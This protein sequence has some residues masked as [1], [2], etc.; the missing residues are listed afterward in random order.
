[1]LKRILLLLFT[2]GLLCPHLA[3][4]SFSG[5]ER[6]IIHLEGLSDYYFDADPQLDIAQVSGEA[7]ASRFTPVAE[8]KIWTG[9]AAPAAWLRFVVPKPELGE[10]YG[11][12]AEGEKPVSQWLL[13]VRPSFS[14]ILDHVD[15][16][17]PRRDGGFDQIRSGAKEV[18]R[19]SEP[20]SRFF[21]FELPPGAFDGKPCYLRL[22]SMTDVEVNLTIETSV[23]FAQNEG[24]D[25]IAY[26][27]LYGTLL[28]MV[29]YSLFPL[30]SLKDST[31]LYYILYIVSA[32]LWLF[33]VQGH[34]KLVFGQRPRFDQ[35]MLWLCVG[36]MITWGAIFT[37]SFLRLK[38]GRPVLFHLFLVIAVLGLA[39]S[40]AGLVGW[41]GLAFSMSHYLGLVLPI[42]AIAAAIA[43]L[44][45]GFSSAFYYLIAW[46][47]LA[48]GGFAFSLMGLK[49]LSVNFWTTNGM[50]IG[51]AGQSIFLSMA[52]TDRFKRLEIERNRLEKIQAHYR[53]LSLTDAPTGLYN[54]R[55]LT[56]A[57]GLAMTKSNQTGTPLSLILL[58][59]D[60]FK[61]INDTFGHGF[62]D[63]ILG[64]LARSMKS[65]TRECD[66]SCR[67]GGDEFVIILPGISGSDAFQVAERIRNCFASDSLKNF[68]NIDG[69]AMSATVSLGVVELIGKETAEA[70]LARA[71][72]AMYEAKRLGKNR[73]ALQ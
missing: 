28:A 49:V 29:L 46:S 69:V 66:S 42:F 8:R 23:G 64:T 17:V 32:G 16:Y 56:T 71:D 34:A 33:F 26:G 47:F 72:S 63:T 6:P 13:V 48:A 59:I 60:D 53:E 1:M 15:L 3:A 36:A 40:V 14:I 39:V 68:K 37:A 38:D 24:N 11:S 58:D 67:F 41:D 50:A 52:L 35:A 70:F 10:G 54:R 18:M 43:R 30:L 22:S 7:M 25:Y 19:P 65:C 73:S 45:Q 61:N 20:R 5:A 44:S 27:L 9:K 31:Y 2:V 51:M 57:L 62:G 4:A 12:S 55:F 21:V